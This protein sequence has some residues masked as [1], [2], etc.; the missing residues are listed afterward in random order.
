MVV[1]DRN[2]EYVVHHKE[3]HFLY[4]GELRVAMRFIENG[5]KVAR[6]NRAR[7]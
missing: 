3:R 5:E 4:P 1:I 7:G 6:R 2:V